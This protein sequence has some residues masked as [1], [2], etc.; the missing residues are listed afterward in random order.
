MK[1]INLF[2]ILFFK[3]S[4]AS[5]NPLDPYS[6]ENFKEFLKKE[7]LFEIINSIKK[8]Y[9]QDIAII[10][11][12]ELAGTRKGNCRRLVTQYMAPNTT[13]KI[14]IQ[15]IGTSNNRLNIPPKMKPSCQKI[16][17]KKILK[18]KYNRSE[19]SLIYNKILKR[20]C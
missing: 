11:C 2:L 4:M 12:E 16:E 13:V 10:S 3:L 15:N 1:L 19:S 14:K 9:N 18:Q 5:K 8:V 20:V 7:G 17:I 6:I